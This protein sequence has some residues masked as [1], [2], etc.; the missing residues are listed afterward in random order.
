[1]T[2][3]INNQLIFHILRLLN[4]SVIIGFISRLISIQEIVMPK[5]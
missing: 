1:M 3:I 4:L 2:S 5:K